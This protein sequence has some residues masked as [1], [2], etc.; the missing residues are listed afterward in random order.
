MTPHLRGLTGISTDALRTL[1]SSIHRRV[2]ATPLS[3]GELT[4]IG[5]QYCATDLMR[6]LRELDERAV[7]AVLVA[8]LAERVAQEEAAARSQRQLS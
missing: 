8:V 6:E 4:R 7:R 2:V 3:I 1:L 5:L